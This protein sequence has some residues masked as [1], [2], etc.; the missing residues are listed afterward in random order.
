MVEAWNLASDPGERA[1]LTDMPVR[2]K[3]MAIALL[4]QLAGMR[5][6]V[7]A[8]SEGIVA[9][10]APMPEW[11]HPA[12]GGPVG[13]NE[14]EGQTDLEWT[15]EAGSSYVIEYE[16]GTGLLSLSGTIVT[17]GPR[18]DFSAVSEWYWS[19]W[20]VPYGKVRFRVRPTAAV[21]AWSKWM[22]MEL[23]P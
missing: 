11:V 21:D 20:V 8:S 13:Y 7:N 9:S 4:D 22:E 12:T 1:P 14:I 10:V 15:G 2:A 3:D 6:P 16:A 23:R 19:T 5:R 18:Y 17:T